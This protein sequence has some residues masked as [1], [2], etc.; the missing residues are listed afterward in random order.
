MGWCAVCLAAGPVCGSVRHYWLGGC[1]ALF[2][3]ARRLRQVW[4]AG[5][6]AG[7][8]VFPVPLL[9]PRVLRAA[10]G[11]SSRTLARWYAIPCGL[12]VPRAWSGCP[13]GI[14][15]VSFACVCARA[16]AASAP[17]LPTWVGVA[18]AP[19]V[20][21][22]QGAGR[23]VPCGPCPSAFPAS[24]SCAV[25]LAWGRGLR[26]GPC[27]WGGPEPRGAGKGGTAPPWGRGRGA[28]RGGGSLYLGPS[29]CLPWAGTTA[30][31]IGVAQ[32]MEGLVSILPRFMFAW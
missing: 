18:R 3:C 2:V 4:G 10:C 1:S 15:R 29:L 20:V 14:P 19:R 27:V 21:P 26:A 13:S 24:V 5:A 23:A 16:L 11:G 8:C 28:P 32:F 6:G 17:F 31:V 9:P 25:L 12:C 22:V 30:R 7:F